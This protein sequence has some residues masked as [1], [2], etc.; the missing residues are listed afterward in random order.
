MPI[1]KEVL[2]SE[3]RDYTE[4]TFKPIAASK[5]LNFIV[6]VDPSVPDD[7]FTDSYRLQQILK[8]LLSNAFKFTEHG[9][10]TLEIFAPPVSRIPTRT[11]WTADSP[12][13][14]SPSLIPALEYRL[15][16]SS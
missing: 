8:N 16:N 5:N 10:V 7:L 13:L 12:T 6:N 11:T 14:P 3:V 1:R 4:R 9:Q 15:K 2:L